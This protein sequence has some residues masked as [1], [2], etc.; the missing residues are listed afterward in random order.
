MTCYDIILDVHYEIVM[1][2]YDVASI[3]TMFMTSLLYL[4]G[5]T[6]R[7]FLAENVNEYLRLSSNADKQQ[8]QRIKQL[9]EKKNQK[10]TQTVAQLQRKLESY[11][12]SWRSS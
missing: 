1:L 10:S 2:H 11:Q 8:Q 9:F 3:W 5:L 6:E 4:Y 7:F 12:V